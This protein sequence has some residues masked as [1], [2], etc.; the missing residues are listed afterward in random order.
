MALLRFIA[1]AVLI[2]YAIKFIGRLLAPFIMKKMADK[3]N[4]RFQQNFN[5]QQQYQQQQNKKEGEVTVEG[6][7]RKKSKFS[8]D[9]GEYVDYEDIKE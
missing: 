1:I 4:D 2:Y 5:N 9:E 6:Q 3:M 8:K 7:A